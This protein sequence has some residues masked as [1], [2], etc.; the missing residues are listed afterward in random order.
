MLMIHLQHQLSPRP[1]KPL[2]RRKL[3]SAE[4]I[5][6]RTAVSFFFPELRHM[7]S[8]TDECDDGMICTVD[9]NATK[10][11]QFNQNRNL[12]PV[13]LCNGEDGYTE[14]KEDNN[15]NG[16]YNFVIFLWISGN[17]C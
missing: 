13:C 14:D 17:L 2:Q 7:C 10:S 3:S 11:Y 8:N 6:N 4:L 5:W 16:K 15:C 9:T 1:K 12:P